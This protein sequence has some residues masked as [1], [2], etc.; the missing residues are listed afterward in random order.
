MDANTLARRLAD[1]T[2][3]PTPTADA[4]ARAIKAERLEEVICGRDER[5]EGKGKP[6]RF[7]AAWELVFQ[8]E[9]E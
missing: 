9:W 7:V 1:Y 5:P 8:R 4:C 3:R 6:L 2:E